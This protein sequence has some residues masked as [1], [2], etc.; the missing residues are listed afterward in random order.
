MSMKLK[1]TQLNCLKIELGAWCHKFLQVNAEFYVNA[2]LFSKCLPLKRSNDFIS[3]CA[4]LC[5]ENKR[6]LQTMVI[7]I[8]GHNSVKNSLI[9]PIIEL[10]PDF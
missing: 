10:N 4:N 6:K 8:K 1:D 2:E 9:V 3:I 7:F 5:E